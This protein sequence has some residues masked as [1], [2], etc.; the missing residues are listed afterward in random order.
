MKASAIINTMAVVTAAYGPETRQGFCTVRG[1]AAERSST[2]PPNCSWMR[3]EILLKAFRRYIR[4]NGP[5][6][7]CA[8]SVPVPMSV[9]VSVSV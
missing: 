8:R 4:Q 9:S 6:G 5:A 1:L 2:L 7:R 3:Q